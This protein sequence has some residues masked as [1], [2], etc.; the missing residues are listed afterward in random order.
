MIDFKKKNICKE[1]L[2]Q[3]SELAED[4]WDPG[5]K[6]RSLHLVNPTRLKYIERQASIKSKCVLDVGC[7]GGLLSE[8]LAK[9]GA[10]VTAIDVSEPLIIV[11]QNHAKQQQL[12]IDYQCQD[13]EIL[14]KEARRFDIITCIELLEHIPDPQ[15]MVKNC[16]TLLKRSGKLFFSTINRNFK[17]YLYA[18][19]GAEYLFNLLPKGTHD[20]GKLI[21]PSEL[22]K[23]TK[24][25]GLRMSDITGIHYHPFK[26]KFDLSHD[27]SI[28]Y[29]M[30]CSHE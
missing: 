30:C 2:T 28:N 3:F 13:V 12:N 11:A 10:I 16:A 22:M 8:A 9:R 1:E 5:G 6:M 23:W 25:A 26:K 19:I 29:L 21:R 17:A 15:R 20:Y 14:T 24:A 4:W 18:I 7:G 27:V